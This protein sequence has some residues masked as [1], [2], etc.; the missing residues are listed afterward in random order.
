MSTNVTWDLSDLYQS[1]DDPKIRQDL[2]AVEGRAEA[3][4]VEYRGKIGA[5]APAE[6]AAALT[7]YEAIVHDLYFPGVYAE[8]LFAA[9]TLTPA[10]GALMQFVQ[11]RSVGVQRH[12][13]FFELEMIEIPDDRFNALLATPPRP[14]IGITWSIR[15]RRARIAS[16]NRRSASCWRN[17]PPGAE[18]FSRLFEEIIGA[19]TFTMTLHGETKTMTEPEILSQLYSPDREARRAAADGVTAGLQERARLFTFITNTLAYDKAVDDRLTAFRLARRPRATWTMK[20]IPPPC[21]PCWTSVVAHFA[22]VARYYRLKR[23]ILGLDTLYHYD[24]YAPILPDES[25]VTWEEA[26]TTVLD[27]YTPV[28]ARPWGRWPRASSTS[29][30]STPRCAPASVAAPSAPASRPIG[31]PTCCTNF[32]GKKRDVLTLAHELGHGVH[33]LLAAGQHLLQYHPSLAAAETASVFGEML[34][35]NSLLAQTTTPMEKLSL[36]TGKIEDIFATVFRQTAMYRFE[37]DLHAARRAE[38]ELTE[39]TISALWQKNV[40][41]MFGDSVDHGRG[42]RGLVDVHPALHPHPLLRLR[43]RLRPTAG[44]GALRAL[45]ARR[46]GLRAA[47]PGHPARRRLQ[48]PRANH[49]RRRHRHL[50]ARLLGRRPANDRRFRRPGRADMGGGALGE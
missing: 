26:Q 49:G 43:L 46:R 19:A 9:D 22:T 4:A 45:P 27:A 39:E 7:A 41:A 31:I 15:A 37:Q 21:I 6:F 50:A 3:F 11:E 17:R 16:P 10:N 33:D 13:I 32:L 18:A 12:L 35:F 38:G 30:G 1:V 44:D 14:R 24:R 34:T 23:E 5:L 48:T 40:Q 25:A 47:L 28:H 29:A 20:W 42:A 8:L 36:L 2:D